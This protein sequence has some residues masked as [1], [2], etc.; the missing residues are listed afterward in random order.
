MYV[1]KD[2]LGEKIKSKFEAGWLKVKNFFYDVGCAFSNIFAKIFGKR[3]QTMRSGNTGA[4]IFAYALVAYP[5][6][7]FL[8]FY[9]YVN[10][11]SILLSLQQYNLD[12]GKFGL[13]LYR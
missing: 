8:V 13:A 10:F 3:Q 1:E 4:M 9:V 11:N 12:T 7:Q 6:L 5:F 2:G